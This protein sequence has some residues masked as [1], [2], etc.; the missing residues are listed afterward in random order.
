MND[1]AAQILTALR[2]AGS[3]GLLVD[4]LV[5]RLGVD[6]ETITTEIQR[7]TSEGL[8]LQKTELKNEQQLLRAQIGDETEPSTLTDL[9][10]CPCFHCLKIGRC[11]L[12]QPDSPANCDELETWM[13]ST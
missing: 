6:S 3:D 9:N 11:G 7:L 5:D 10:G 8:V 13:E 12:R 2:T 4:E 1:I